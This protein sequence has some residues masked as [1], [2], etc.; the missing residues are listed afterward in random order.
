MVMATSTPNPGANGSRAGR[1]SQ[2]TARWPDR[3][4]AMR[5]PVARAMP[6][7]ARPMATPNPPAP[8]WAGRSAMARS[9][10]P[11]STGSSRRS[12]R[13][14]VSARSASASSSTAGSG[15]S[16]SATRPMR[17]A[18]PALRAPP[19]PR[20]RGRSR[21]WAPASRALAAVASVDPSLTTSTSATPGSARSARTVAPTR[22]ASSLAGTRASTAALAL[23]PPRRRSRALGPLREEAGGAV[24]DAVLAGGEPAGGCPRGPRPGRAGR[25]P[26]RPSRC[27]TPGGSPPGCRA[28]RGSRRSPGGRR[29]PRPRPPAAAGAGRDL[30]GQGD[31]ERVRGHGG[32]GGGG[33]AEQHEDRALARE[34]VGAGGQRP[35]E[36]AGRPGS[37]RPGGR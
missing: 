7:R 26:C 25:R 15:L 8:C 13:P 34:R 24:L 30:V 29:P 20:L 12:S 5:R 2:R 1:A 4:S 18:S 19:L 16:R 9:A 6:R 27:R 22:S 31:E 36:L 37:R 3:G 14:A 35:A 17:A 11:A 32:G 33:R 21:Q 10:S 28:G 23:A